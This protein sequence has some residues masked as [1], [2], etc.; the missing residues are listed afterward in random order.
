[1]DYSISWVK[2]EKY[3]EL[4]GDSVDAVMSR[5]KAGKWLDGHQCKIVDSRL[6]I[7]INAAQRW[8]EEWGKTPVHLQNQRPTKRDGR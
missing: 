3:A 7:D 8:V 5:R 4:T 2:V 1:M 6:W